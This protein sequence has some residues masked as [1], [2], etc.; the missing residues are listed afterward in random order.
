VALI[1]S[2]IGMFNTMTIALLE[3]I[4]EIGIMRAIGVTRKDIKI[5]FLMESVIMGFMGGVGGVLVGFFVSEIANIGVNILAKT[6]GGQAID[7]FYNP[8]WFIAVIIIFSTL[9]GF[10]TGVY[11]SSKAGKL[12]P[13]TALRYK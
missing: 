2:A 12:N 13:L 11:P 7:L 4:N 9:I 1:V 8:P 6:F 10:M 3:R 5:L